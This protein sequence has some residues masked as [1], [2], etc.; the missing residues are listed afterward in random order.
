VW[1]WSYASKDGGGNHR[2]RPESLGGGGDRGRR[3]R[4]GVERER[5]RGTG[6]GRFDRPGTQSVGLDPARW[7]GLAN[8]PGPN[9][10]NLKNQKGLKQYFK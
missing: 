1:R 9:F 2:R 8:G 5:A 6:L 7:A 10:N 4:L 3:R